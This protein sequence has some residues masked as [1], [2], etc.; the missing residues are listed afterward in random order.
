VPQASRSIGKIQAPPL[1]KDHTAALCKIC[2]APQI[3]LAKFLA[4]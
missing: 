3:F 2:S 1:V 4:P